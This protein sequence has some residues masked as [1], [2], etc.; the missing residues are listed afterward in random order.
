MEPAGVLASQ[1]DRADA[2]VLVDADQ[3]RGL[4]EATAVG[5]VAE[6]GEALVAG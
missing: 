2:G 3:P 4:A 6:H 1:Q 5:Q